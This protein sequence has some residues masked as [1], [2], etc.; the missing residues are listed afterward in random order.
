MGQRY[1]FLG[2]N[3]KALDALDRAYEV[4]SILIPLLKTEPSFTP[5]HSDPRFQ[6]LAR[7]IGL[8]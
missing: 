8:P 1:A 4:R 6:V 7:K 2:E 3:A 5:L